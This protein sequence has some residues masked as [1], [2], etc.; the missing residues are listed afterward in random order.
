MKLRMT[1]GYEY[2]AETYQFS[3]LLNGVEV[4]TQLAEADEIGKGWEFLE[5][6]LD[7]SQERLASYEQQLNSLMDEED[8]KRWSIHRQ[9]CDSSIR[10]L[11]SF[12]KLVDRRKKAFEEVRLSMLG[13][14]QTVLGATEETL[15]LNNQEA[16]VA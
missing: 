2:L 5:G 15:K 13:I 14:I 12:S 6:F 8:Q 9:I 7:K 10:S 11:R 1:I 4:G 3:S 16:I